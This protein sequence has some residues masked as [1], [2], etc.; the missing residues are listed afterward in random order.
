M[1]SSSSDV[2]RSFLGGDGGDG[3][4]VASLDALRAA[5]AEAAAAREAERAKQQQ[6]E[7]M[8]AMLQAAEEELKLRSNQLEL[9]N[10]MLQSTESD[11]VR[12]DEQLDITTQ[13][14]R[15]AEEEIKAQDATNADLRREVTSM[16]DSLGKATR[17][18]SG[19]RTA[20]V[21]GSFGQEHGEEQLDR[22]RIAATLT[23]APPPTMPAQLPEQQRRWDAVG[24]GAHGPPA[25]AARVLLAEASDAEE[26]MT[27]GARVRE[28]SYASTLDYVA[29]RV[30][31]GRP[32]PAA[33]AAPVPI[34]SRSRIVHDEAEDARQ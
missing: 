7:L 16:R 19:H 29:A 27:R 9:T 17:R 15:K 12:K 18:G 10:A 30:Q 26:H 21:I 20:D 14:L 8:T 31:A 23:A 2:W 4:P 6:L 5:R 3:A 22:M 33:A 11:L 1:A 24:S 28:N 32:P 25:A 13:M 34:A